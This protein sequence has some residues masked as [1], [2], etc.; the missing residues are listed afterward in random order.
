MKNAL[1]TL[2]KRLSQIIYLACGIVIVVATILTFGN[3]LG[4]YFMGQSAEWAEEV[5]RY[6]IILAVLLGSAPMVTDKSHICMAMIIDIISGKVTEPIKKKVI[7]LY[8]YLCAIAMFIFCFVMFLWSAELVAKTDMLSYSLIF[9]MQDVY[10]IMPIGFAIICIFCILK[11]IVLM[12]E[13]P[14]TLLGKGGEV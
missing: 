5:I 14:Q 12:F 1:I 11:V 9:R 8:D 6:L 2:E 3:T 13:T 7:L 4:R 10:A